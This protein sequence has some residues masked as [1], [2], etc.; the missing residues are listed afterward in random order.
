MKDILLDRWLL[1]S[2][3]AR[4]L[5]RVNVGLPAG[6]HK[7]GRSIPLKSSAMRAA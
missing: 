2:T 7:L 5:I 4:P 1:K 3:A 6:M